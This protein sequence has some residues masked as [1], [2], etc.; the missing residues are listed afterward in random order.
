[1]RDKIH[2]F[3]IWATPAMWLFSLGYA[4]AH[5]DWSIALLEALLVSYSLERAL[6]YESLS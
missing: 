5:R 1:M 2:R 3:L 6:H 4:I